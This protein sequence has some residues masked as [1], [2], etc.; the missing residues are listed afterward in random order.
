VT[1][2]ESVWLHVLLDLCRPRKL[3]LSR[4][5]GLISHIQ[6]VEAISDVATCAAVLPGSI[7]QGNGQHGH[8]LG[9][10]SPKRKSTF[11]KYLKS[12]RRPM[13]R[14]LNRLEVFSTP[15]FQDTR[16]SLPA[17]IVNW[18]VIQIRRSARG[19]TKC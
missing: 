4:W 14:G 18:Y 3:L 1:T 2:A 9:L 17:E 7:L 11:A 19:V 6:N 10:K 12:Q 8:R 5:E 15:Q 13:Q 16:Q